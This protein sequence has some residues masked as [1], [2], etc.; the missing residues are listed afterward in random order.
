MA[1]LVDDAFQ[2]KGLGT[3]LLER[4]ALIAAKR[5]I[6]RFQAFVLAENQKMLNVFMESGFQVRAHR[7]SG[8]VEVEFEILL[9]ER[10][11]ER[12][13]WREKV[14]TLASLH[15]FF[16]PRGVAVVGASRD[17]E[18]IGYRVLENLI[19]GRFQGPVYPVNEAIGK[20]GARWGPF[21]PTPGWRASP[22]PWTWR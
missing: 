19:F 3:L 2:G 20:E 12:F 5:G 7:D 8:E 18:S 1:F 16:F 9:E 4:L 10:A 22:A 15:P 13:E 17:P 21:S 14:S 11:A 6:R